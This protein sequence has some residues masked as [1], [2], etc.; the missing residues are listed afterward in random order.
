MTSKWKPKSDG[1]LGVLPI[2]APLVVQTAFV[3]KKWAPSAPKVRTKIEKTKKDSRE[4]PDCEK[5]IQKSSLFEAWPG[6]L[7]E[8]LTTKSG[9]HYLKHQNLQIP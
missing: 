5:E 1:I 2:G 8:A 4:L 9:F 3:I 7:R 6:G